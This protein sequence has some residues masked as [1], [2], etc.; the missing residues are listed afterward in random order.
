M[1]GDR[2]G[3]PPD[4]DAPNSDAQD[5][6]VPQTPPAPVATEQGMI[7]EPAPPAPF[8]ELDEF[9]ESVTGTGRRALTWLTGAALAV[10][11]ALWLGVLSVAQATDERPALAALE[12]GVAALT[13]V[14]T[15]LDLQL[16]AVQEQ[17][18]AGSETLTVPGFPVRDAG[19][20]AADVTRSD[21]SVDR[22]LLRE[23][24]LRKSARLVHTRGVSA[25]REAGGETEAA[26]RLSVSGGIRTLLNGLSSDNH[27]TAVVWLWPLGGACLLLGA[28]L[29]SLAGGLGRFI[30]LGAALTAAAVPVLLAALAARL[31][32]G[33][34]DA[35]EPLVE[36]FV[37]IGRQL[38]ALPLRNALWVAAAGVA[39][40]LPA[41]VLNA[42]FERSVRRPAPHDTPEGGR[43]SAV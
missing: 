3:G 7:D 36:E 34:V 32:L 29:L 4:A 38:A 41:A 27:G 14:E 30:A 10:A 1:S 40:A 9:D 17:A 23:A 19:V 22:A 37:S 5:A 21:G 28:L 6:R 39:V 26:S 18:D 2:T 25:F 31:A 13:G 12:R 20:P 42:F 43:R 16:E 33:F 35:G 11:L 24:L 8:D 15:L